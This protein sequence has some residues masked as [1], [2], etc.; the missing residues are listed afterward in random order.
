MQEH[1]QT[2]SPN[3]P[4]K[5]DRIP[6]RHKCAGLPAVAFGETYEGRYRRYVLR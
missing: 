2:P 5:E 6:P 4:D 1:N 3:P